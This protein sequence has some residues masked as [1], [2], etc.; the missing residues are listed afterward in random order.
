MH[1]SGRR[2]RRPQL[3][4]RE[5]YGGLEFI[6][7]LRVDFSRNLRFNPGDGGSPGCGF[8]A[9]VRALQLHPTCSSQGA[10]TCRPLLQ[11]DQW[12][13]WNVH[14]K[15]V[16]YFSFILLLSYISYVCDEK[17]LKNLEGG[18]TFRMDWLMVHMG[19]QC[20]FI[21]RILPGSC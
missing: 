12:W 9:P 13:G 7:P 4:Q 18:L 19:A 10:T 14:N 16:L 1:P 2:L 21:V 5:F 11:N 6:V 15:C 20:A 17:G 8:I 3:D